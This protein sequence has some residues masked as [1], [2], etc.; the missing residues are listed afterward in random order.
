MIR[1]LSDRQIKAHNHL[2][3]KGCSLIEGEIKT[4][5]YLF[6][7]KPTWLIRLKLR[8]ALQL[9]K[10]ALKINDSNASSAC[11]I[12]KIF[13]RLGNNSMAM[14]WLEK[15]CLLDSK[16]SV[17]FREA[18]LMALSL[19]SSDKAV[20]FAE[21]ALILKPDDFGLYDNLALALLVAGKKHDAKR[22]AQQAVDANGDDD[23]SRSVLKLINYIIIEELECPKTLE[24]IEEMLS[25][26][27]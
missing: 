22:R 17:L 9:F 10:K 21:Q 12:A 15:A 23:I 26:I 20:L 6:L 11:F 13:Q 7:R 1:H 3:K 24:E 5:E 14:E 27:K 16:N 4:S 19:G 2:F 25:T 8:I 18:S